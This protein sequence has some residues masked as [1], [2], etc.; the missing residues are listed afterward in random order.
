M[1]RVG[2]CRQDSLRFFLRGRGRKRLMRYGNMR[3]HFYSAM[4]IL[5]QE[6]SAKLRVKNATHKQNE[7][8]DQ[9]NRDERDKQVANNQAVAQT[10]EQAISPPTEEADEEIYAGQDSQ[11]LQEAEQAPGGVEKR[12]NQS[13]G[14]SCG[15]NEIEP[16]K[17]MPDFLE[18]GAEGCHRTMKT[19]LYL[20]LRT[21]CS[22]ST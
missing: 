12:K 2:L 18:A 11:I 1:N 4:N 20:N 21:E 15:R 5:I 9:Q 7:R 10:P 17:A 16:R 14:S 22:G 13:S 8:H 6:V 19:I 3:H